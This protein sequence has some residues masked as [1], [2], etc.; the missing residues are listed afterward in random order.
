MNEM[1]NLEEKVALLETAVLDERKR[2]SSDRLDISFGELI[3]LYKN[4]ELIIR[5]QYQRLF[6]WSEAQKTALIESILLSIPIPP[7]FV[8]EDK[9]GVWELVDGLQ[10][11]STFI[12]FFGDLKSNGQQIDCQVQSN[13]LVAN[14]EEDIDE[15]DDEGTDAT[16]TK[17]KWILQEGGLVK[18]LQ[19]FNVD[20]L[21]GNLKINLKR[22]VCRVEILRGESSTSMKY[23]LFKRL[24]SGGSKLTPQEIRNAIYRGVDPRLNEL[25]L[26]IANNELF[27]QLTAL[28]TGRLDELYDQ[29]LVLR[30]FAF[31]NNSENID[32]NMERFLNSFMEETV[33][34]TDFDYEG[35]EALL[36]R[37]LQL[38]GSANDDKIFRNH[39]GFF[40]PAYFEGIL[41]GVAQNID[42]YTDNIDLLKT[43]ITELKS[44][45][46]FRRFSGSASNS[47]SRIRNRLQRIDQIFR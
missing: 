6:R 4:G 46:E 10:R 29:E 12:S 44:D 16:E 24:N 15:Y 25:L 5:P 43:K 28:S 47:R 36:M 27:R 45:A 18:A 41:I 31:Y 22:A 20:T 26:K 8:A 37:V 17:N 9:D 19:G 13:S 23:E 14:E 32:D 7:I 2:L 3:N 30:F 34:N 42:K 33:K 11:V 1:E 39:R 21:P 38:V 40:V 35:Y